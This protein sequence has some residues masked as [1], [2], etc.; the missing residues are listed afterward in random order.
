MDEVMSGGRFARPV[1]RGNTVER[2]VGIGHQNVHALLS[3]FER[4]GFG[5]APR[6]L[7]MTQDGRREILSFIE[8]EIGYPPLTEA[9]RC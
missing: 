3:H 6:Y 5:L 8:G 1:R 9:V 7:G 4:Q 2:D